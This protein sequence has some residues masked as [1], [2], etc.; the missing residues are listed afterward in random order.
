M[1]QYRSS[2]D[3]ILEAV[4]AHPG[5]TLEEVEQQLSDLHWSEVFQQVDRLSRSGQLRL[6]QSSL[7]L[8]TTLYIQSPIEKQSAA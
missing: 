2:A 6:A 3:R 7:G 8:T 5:C 1:L 4:R